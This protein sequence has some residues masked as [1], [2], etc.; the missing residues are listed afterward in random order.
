MAEAPTQLARPD[1]F[2]SSSCPTL[3]PQELAVPPVG[4]K[5]LFV[6]DNLT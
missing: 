4:R 5:I 6:G 1:A 2:E 3:I